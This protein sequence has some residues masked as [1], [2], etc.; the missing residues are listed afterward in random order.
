MKK[1]LGIVVLVFFLS[2]N[3]SF[4]AEPPTWDS[5]SLNTNITSHGWK[6]KSF[7]SNITDI[8]IE[9]YTLVKGNWILKCS[10]F[11]KNSESYGYCTLP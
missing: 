8:P 2:G 10:I 3:I 11:F 5:K 7:S 9:I 1:I 6:I 4:S